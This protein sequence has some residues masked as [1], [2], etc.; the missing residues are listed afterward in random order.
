M[1]GGLLSLIWVMDHYHF[2]SK[3]VST[4]GGDVLQTDVTN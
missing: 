3:V 4:I 2:L 1:S